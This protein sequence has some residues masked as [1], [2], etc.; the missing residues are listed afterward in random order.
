MP[1]MRKKV[2]GHWPELRVPTGLP[3][4]L[5]SH[6][7]GRWPRLAVSKRARLGY[8]GRNHAGTND[9]LVVW[10]EHV[11]S[12]CNAAC[13]ARVRLVAACACGSCGSSGNFRRLVPLPLPDLISR[14]LHVSGC[15]SLSIVFHTRW[16][17]VAA[18]RTSVACIERVPNSCQTIKHHNRCR[19]RH[20]R[21]WKLDVPLASSAF[22]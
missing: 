6:L 13:G 10:V 17:L 12:P 7:Q 11:H 5:R 9:L 14:L 1:G 8:K 15:C 18:C 19:V 21:D 22:S 20:L 16:H 3:L 4:F 2:G